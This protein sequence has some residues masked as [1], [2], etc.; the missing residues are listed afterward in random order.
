MK[1]VLLI[2]L[3]SIIFLTGCT[4]EEIIYR[5]PDEEYKEVEKVVYEDFKLKDYRPRTGYKQFKFE[6]PGSIKQ[7]E[8]VFTN[9]YV[10][11]SWVLDKEETEN[12]YNVLYFTNDSDQELRIYIGRYTQTSILVIVEE[13]Y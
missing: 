11:K 6:G 8:E 10:E 12:S 3:S 2:L 13:P 4:K 7:A 1:K 9:Y 5:D